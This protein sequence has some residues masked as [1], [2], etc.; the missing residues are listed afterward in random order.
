MGSTLVVQDFESNSA[1]LVTGK[2]EWNARAIIIEAKQKISL[3][4]GG[5]FIMIDPSGVTIYGTM[6][7]INSGGFGTETGD[8]DF[9]DASDAA[10]AD[11]GEPGNLERHYSGGGGGGWSKAKKRKLRS[12]HYTA[13]PRAGEDPRV[14]A[15]RNTLQQIP[16]GR[17]A[18]EVYDRYGLNP[19]FTPGPG[20][21]YSAPNGVN[22]DPSD[23]N[24]ALSM[25]HEMNHAEHDHEGTSPDIN[26]PN[27]A[28]YVD[29]MLKEEAQSSSLENKAA[30]EMKDA[31]LPPENP[32]VKGPYDKGYKK[33]V[34]DEK[35]RNPNATPEEL[36]TAGHQAGQQAVND[37]FRD[38][39][40]T[41]STPGNPPYTKYY[42]DA[43][44]GQHPSGGAGGSP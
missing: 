20:T 14:T 31:G 36:D 39:K 44:D 42:G 41:T 4:V 38:G 11:T 23:P 22:F 3:K 6:V 43:W 33:G 26:N 30:R 15:I 32:T 12:Q 13:P 24:T 16:T 18:L 19:T 25:V 7:K 8:P 21:V 28:D 37:A 27:R 17:H 40:V 2:A 10:A 35:A 29:G 34:E 9:Q 1:T 5:N